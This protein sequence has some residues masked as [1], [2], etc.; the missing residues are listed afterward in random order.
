[1]DCLYFTK[2]MQHEAQWLLLKKNP[3]YFFCECLWSCTYITVNVSKSYAFIPSAWER[4]GIHQPFCNEP[5]YNVD[6]TYCSR[7]FLPWQI[8]WWKVRQTSAAM[9]TK[10]GWWKCWVRST[11]DCL[12]CCRARWRTQWFQRQKSQRCFDLVGKT[13]VSS[14]AT[15]YSGLTTTFPSLSMLVVCRVPLRAELLR[16]VIMLSPATYRLRLLRDER[17]LNRYK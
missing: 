1:M 14:H 11:S 2:I 4:N 8:F 7:D 13:D 16:D 3:Q 12:D 5:S 9:P 6:Q 15:F 10:F 17:A